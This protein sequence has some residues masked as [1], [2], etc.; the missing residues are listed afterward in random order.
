MILAGAANPGAYPLPPSWNAHR[1]ALSVLGLNVNAAD[2]YGFGG[3]LGFRYFRGPAPLLLGFGSLDPMGDLTISAGT[4]PDR[5]RSKDRCGAVTEMR[6]HLMRERTPVIVSLTPLPGED[7]E[8]ELESPSS[9]RH[10]YVSVLRLDD[11]RVEYSSG[12]SADWRRLGYSDWYGRLSGDAKRWTVIVGNGH[13]TDVASRVRAA[14]RRIVFR[15]RSRPSRLLGRAIRARGVLSGS[16]RPFR[17]RRG[18]RRD[19]ARLGAARRGNG[20]RVVRRISGAKRRPFF[21]RLSGCGGAF[22]R[23]GLAMARR[24]RGFLAW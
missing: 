13:F 5:R 23:A 8:I 7:E 16:P 11:E 24:G 2:T 22:S 4:W 9:R 17:K 14:L 15:F 12:P 3:G 6:E 19:S 20:P 10:T 18:S 21:A 1:H